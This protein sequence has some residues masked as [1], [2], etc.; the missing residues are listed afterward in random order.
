MKSIIKT[1]MYFALVLFCSTI[2]SQKF[3]PVEKIPE[4]KALV[5]IYRP[6][7]VLG[8][9]VHYTVNVNEEKVSEA[10][11]KNDSYLLYFAEPGRH[12]FWGM[13][14][15]NRKEAILDVEAGKT[16]YIKGSCCVFTIP[17]LEKAKKQIKKCRL[18]K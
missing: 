9:A 12:T 10:H 11:L 5:Y 17:E 2:F 3:T 13:V 8:M 18:S 6:S 14:S 15:G 16:Y 1:L 4:G 7:K